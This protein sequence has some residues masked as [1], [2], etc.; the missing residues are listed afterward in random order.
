MSQ[1]VDRHC[2]KSA[3]GGRKLCSYHYHQARGGRRRAIQQCRDEAVCD[4]ALKDYR[5]R[6]QKRKARGVRVRRAT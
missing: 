5:R 1:C 4:Q 2:Y 6:M 3:I